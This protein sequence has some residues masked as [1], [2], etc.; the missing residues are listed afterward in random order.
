M[1]SLRAQ[2][3]PGAEVLTFAGTIDRE[4]LAVIQ[5]T[6]EEGCER[7]DPDEW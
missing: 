6:I 3:T 7:V 5:Q 4:D 2:G 1:A